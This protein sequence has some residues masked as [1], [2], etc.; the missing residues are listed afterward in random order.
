M[1]YLVQHPWT[2]A[3][4]LGEHVVLVALALAFALVIALPLGVLVARRPRVGAVVLGVLGAIYTIPSL[5]L[6]ALLVAAFGLGTRAAVIAL[7]AYAQMML[8]RNVAAGL[9]GVPAPVLDAAAGLGLTARQRLWR[10][11]LPL[12]MPALL[13]GVRIAAVALIAIGTVAAW[14]DAGGLG[15]L[16]FEGLHQND[17]PKILAGALGAIVLALVVDVGLRRLERAAART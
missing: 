12:A 6:L 17:T 7:V 15:A 13:G 1:T 10:V 5:A 3:E 2:V 9:A 14:V 4:R 16:I 8:V 11:E